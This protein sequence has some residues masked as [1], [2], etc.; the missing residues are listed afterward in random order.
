MRWR[1]RCQFSGDPPVQKLEYIHCVCPG[2]GIRVAFQA[3][4]FETLVLRA[5]LPKLLGVSEHT[6]LLRSY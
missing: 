6:A 2:A 4:E 5:S 1:S 3:F